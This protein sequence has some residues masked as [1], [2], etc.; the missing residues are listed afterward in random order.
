MADDF[1]FVQAPVIVNVTN[2]SVSNNTTA[3][4]ATAPSFEFDTAAVTS[5][6]SK[7]YALTLYFG[8]S[9]AAK[10][11][12]MLDIDG[13]QI[14]SASN[15]GTAAGNSAQLPDAVQTKLDYVPSG[16]VLK[17]NKG[18]RI[19]VYAYNSGSDNAARTFSIYML[20][21]IKPEG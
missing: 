17:L 3:F 7:L 6:E 13:V 14:F 4:P 9:F 11:S 2:I 8:T 15:S 21:G 20:L 18:A 10:Y 16:V 1:E 5:Y 19:R 12:Y